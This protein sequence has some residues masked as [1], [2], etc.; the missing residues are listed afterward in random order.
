M[1][2]NMQDADCKKHLDFCLPAFTSNNCFL[3]FC[4]Y[5]MKSAGT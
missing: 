4:D 5:F 1:E 2:K 3:E